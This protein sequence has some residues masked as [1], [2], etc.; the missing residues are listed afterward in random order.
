MEKKQFTNN[1]IKIL[2]LRQNAKD[3]EILRE[4]EKLDFEVKGKMGFMS[5]GFLRSMKKLGFIE[6]IAERDIF[7][8]KVI[9]FTE[10]DLK[11][12]RG[13]IGLLIN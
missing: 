1:I 9:E 7:R 13:A 12:R 3:D 2:G 4:I 6:Y 11:E 8:T 5:S 10:R